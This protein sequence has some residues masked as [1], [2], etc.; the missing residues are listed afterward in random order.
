[1]E[2]QSK[3]T[4]MI[5]KAVGEMAEK[6]EK[7]LTEAKNELQ[8]DITAAKLAAKEAQEKAEN[9]EKSFAIIKKLGDEAPKN[10]VFSK[11]EAKAQDIASLKSNRSGSVSMDVKA[12]A[13]M[14][15][16]NYSGGTVG[17]TSFDS[18]FT[19]VVRRAPFLRQIVSV[20]PIGTQGISWAEQANPDP[21][22]AG[23][24]AEGAAKT[25]TDFDIVERR[26]VARKITAYTKASK[27]ALDDIAYLAAQINQELV[28]LVEL[29]LDEQILS[30][31]NTGQNLKGI[32]Q[33]ASA[34]SVAGSALAL[35]VDQA[36]NF[37]VIRAAAWQIANTG[38][39]KFQPNYV[40][41]NPVDAALMDMTKN[42]QG[43]YVIPP[44]VSAGGQ[45]IY[46]LQ[47][48]E[49]VGVTAGEFVVGDFR[50]ATLGIREGITL[51]VGY[52]N[53]DF[54]KNLVTILAE[55]RAFHY[56]RTNDAGSF[57]SGSFASAKAALE[58]V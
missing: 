3:N 51:N 47:V 44:F 58:T 23:M 8:E 11:L 33:Y 9:L 16:A 22:A 5:I 1:M 50:K 32:L 46:G 15:S 7:S 37:D 54:T 19:R 35:G 39:G 24:T 38:K 53:D 12:A 55:M 52:E 40:L 2:D 56:V 18:E 4:E 34:F 26:E 6:H 29:K 21:G 31:D 28:E 25:Q 17:L 13:T 42:T 10:E 49:N 30:G 14:T 20:R 57:V 27:E 41:V 45:T 36:N 43:S 48:I